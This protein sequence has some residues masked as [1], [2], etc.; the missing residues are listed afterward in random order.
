VQLEGNQLVVEGERKGPKN[1]ARIGGST[2]LPY[3]RFYR[4]IDLP[5]GLDP[6][7]IRCRVH[8]GMLDVQ[9]PIAETMKPRQIAIQSSA[10]RKAIAAKFAKPI[11]GNIIQFCRTPDRIG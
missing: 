9:L 7:K 3:G 10:S 1:F 11:L 5:N 6:N 4:A 2:R 8:D